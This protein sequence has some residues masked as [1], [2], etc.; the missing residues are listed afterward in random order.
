MPET[1]SIDEF[2]S[3]VHFLEKEPKAVPALEMIQPSKVYKD[4]QDAL[5]MPNSDCVIVFKA[6]LPAADISAS[7]AAH[8]NKA[9]TDFFTRVFI[10]ELASGPEMSQDK[11]EARVEM[12]VEQMRRSD[13][14]RIAFFSKPGNRLPPNLNSVLARNSVRAE[15]IRIVR[16]E[17]VK[18]GRRKVAATAPPPAPPKIKKT[19]LKKRKKENEKKGKAKAKPAPKGKGKKSATAPTTSA[20]EGFARAI[21]A[22][23]DLDTVRRDY[24]GGLLAATRRLITVLSEHWELPAEKIAEAFQFAAANSQTEAVA[25]EPTVCVPPLPEIGGQPQVQAQ[26]QVQAE[27]KTETQAVED[28]EDVESCDS[29]STPAPGNDE[30]GKAGDDDEG[31]GEKTEPEESEGESDS[32]EDSGVT[33]K[34]PQ[35]Q[36]PSITAATK[37]IVK[38]PLPTSPPPPRGPAGLSAVSQNNIPP[39]RLP[40]AAADSESTHKPP[41]LVRQNQALS[42]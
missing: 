11:L 31:E 36:V 1:C 32:E 17:T 22:A 9:S 34:M 23:I 33:K 30:E 2:D 29:F 41:A 35:P 8:I 42:E 21:M 13:L 4:V 5:G 10:F 14:V 39:L 24:K 19:N 38:P 7:C 18:Q 28:M 27:L 25:A 37:T 12:A 26:S 20:D 16:A 40:G 15:D 3:F 6:N